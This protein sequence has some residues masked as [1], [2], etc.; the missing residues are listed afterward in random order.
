MSQ[1]TCPVVE[2]KQINKHP[3]ADKLEVITVDG[4]VCLAQIGQWKVGDRAILVPIDS[5]VPLS[6]PEFDFL[7][8]DNTGR[9]EARIKAKRLRGVFSDGLLVP[10]PA[11]PWYKLKPGLGKDA[12]KLLGARKFEEDEIP[13]DHANT[14]RRWVMIRVYAFLRLFGYHSKRPNAGRLPPPRHRYPNGDERKAYDLDHYKKFKSALEGK[15]VVISE[16]VHGSHCTLHW[17]GDRCLVGSRN[18]VYGIAADNVYAGAARK[19]G[20]PDKMARYPDLVL[21]GEVLGVQDLTYGHSKAYPGFVAFDLYHIKERRFLDFG[22]FS[23]ICTELGIPMVPVLYTGPYNPDTIE[24]LVNPPEN[25]KQ[26]KPLLSAYDEKTLREGVVV[27]PVVETR[28]R[29]GRVSLKF[30]SEAYLLRANGTEH[31]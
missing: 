15:E 19:Y 17:E 28:E 4:T 26:K 10:I 25:V 8:K 16:K 23:A 21:H 14:V 29:F 5:V 3:N 22:Q 9:T 7:K 12:A 24:G 20:L 30:V 6:R 2:I 27:K 11:T 18:L 31:H 13:V 1:W